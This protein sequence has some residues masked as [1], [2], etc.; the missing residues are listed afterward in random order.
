M[1]LDTY[2]H[3]KN[4]D[5]RNTALRSLGRAQ[6]PELIQKTL[7][8]PFGGEVKEQDVYIPISALRTY[9]AGIEALYGWMTEN[10]DQIKKTFPASLS[11]HGTI[12]AMCTSSFTSEA[13]LTRIERFFADKSTTGFDQSLAQSSDAIKAKCAWLARDR[14]DVKEWALAYKGKT[15]KAEL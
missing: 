8:L 10:Y 11:M 14:E 7:T 3:S 2:L 1:I 15:I 4:T 13:A 9:P 6:S 12:V 5:E